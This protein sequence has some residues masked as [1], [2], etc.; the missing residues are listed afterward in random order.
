MAGGR[1]FSKRNSVEISVE[2]LEL[3]YFLKFRSLDR[4][5]WVFVF[6][7]AR[8]SNALRVFGWILENQNPLKGTRR[9]PHV[10]PSGRGVT[11]GVWGWFLFT[12]M[13]IGFQRGLKGD[14]AKLMWLCDEL[15]VAWC[16]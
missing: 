14:K 15:A 12:Y 5:G 1:T 11:D 2:F 4:S 13:G 9:L 8:L 10:D 3:K 6:K 16:A 7:R